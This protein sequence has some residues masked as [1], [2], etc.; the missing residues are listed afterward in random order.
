[1]SQERF[2]MPRK[3]FLGTVRKHLFFFFARFFFSKNKSVVTRKKN[4]ALKKKCFVS[5]SRIRKK[6]LASEIIFV[7]D[8]DRICK[9]R[10]RKSMGTCKERR[11]LPSRNESLILPRKIKRGNGSRKKR[12]SSNKGLCESC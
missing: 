4:L 11:Y 10:S 6:I 1:M 7:E 9:E 2:L 5:K 12:S 3:C 8:L